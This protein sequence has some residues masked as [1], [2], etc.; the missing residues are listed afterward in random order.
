VRLARP[1]GAPVTTELVPKQR[2][3]NQ[4][5]KI[6]VNR[7]VNVTMEKVMSQAK[8]STRRAI[9]AGEELDWAERRPRV[10]IVR[11]N[12]QQVNKARRSNRRLAEEH[13]VAT[14]DERCRHPFSHAADGPA[15]RGRYLTAS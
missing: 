12:R 5:E 2:A 9:E 7:G 10:G 8:A 11:V 6:V 14:K 3:G 4:Q 13:T 15:C 1:H